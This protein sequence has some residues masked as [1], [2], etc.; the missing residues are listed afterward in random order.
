MEAEKPE[1]C[2]ETCPPT[3]SEPMVERLSAYRRLLREMALEGKQR[4]YSHELAALECVTSAQIRRDVMTIGYSGSPAKGYDVLGLR[5]HI[6]RILAPALQTATVIVGMGRLGGALA[7]YFASRDGERKIVATFDVDP[8]RTGRVLHGCR[9][10]HIDE[11]EA[12]L[13]DEPA[14]AGVIAVPDR[15]AQEVADR[16]IKAGVCGLLN[17][18]PV[19]LRV[20]Q[21]VFAERIDIGVLL[22]KVAFFGSAQPAAQEKQ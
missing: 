13:A 3:L 22:N 14:S 7:A 9:C 20:P 21:H 11:L 16:L 18:A 4:V 2:P 5:E 12:R 8:E 19:R 1:S 17:F 10:Y 6:D 15:C